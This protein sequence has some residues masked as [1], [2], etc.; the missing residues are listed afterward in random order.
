MVERP[1]PLR[2]VTDAQSPFHGG[3]LAAQERAG[4]RDAADA[5]GRR[6]IRTFMP[7]QHREFFPMLPFLVLGGVDAS[8]RPWPSLRVGEPGFVS[9]PDARSLHV[10]GSVLP[11]DPLAGTWVDGALVGALGI[12][13]ATRRRN[14]VNGVITSG[15]GNAFTLAVNQS[16][17]NCAKYIQARVPTF[18][19]RP[20]GEPVRPPVRATALDAADRAMLA[21]ADTFFIASA[22]TDGGAGAA[23]GADVS[24]RGGVPGFVHV[25]AKGVI[26]SPDFVGNRFFNTIGNLMHDPRAGLLF[27]DFANGDLLYVAATAEIVWDGPALDA[28]PGAQRLI[29]F[30]VSEVVRTPGVLPFRWSEAEMA[31][32]F[33]GQASGRLPDALSPAPWREVTVS[34]V[35]DESATV[36]SFLFEAV[37]GAALPAYLPGQYLPLRLPVPGH[38]KA[39]VRTYTLSEAMLPA[40]EGATAARRY[41]ISVKREGEASA[42]LHDHLQVGMALAAGKPAG[43]FTFDAASR[44]PAVL[45]SAGIGI[46]PMMAM[47][48]HLLALDPGA[49]VWFIHGARDAAHRP[50]ADVLAHLRESH[51]HLSLHLPNSADGVHVDL[52]YLKSVLPFDDYDFYLCGPTAF[53]QDMYDGLRALNVADARIRFEA[54]G[55]A[56]VRR[57]RAAATAAAV[58]AIG[59]GEP[60]PEALPAQPAEATIE[61]IRSGTRVPWSRDDGNLLDFAEKHGVDAQSSCRSGL[62]GTCATRVVDGKLI[63]LMPP[64]ADVPAGH[65]LLCISAP[66]LATGAGQ[67]IRLDL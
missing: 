67:T 33:A 55:P 15:D 51:P 47:L 11:G 32:Q 30:H 29:R 59:G 16:F 34:Q 22:N 20:E 45:I 25:D 57:E 4:V 38:D 48:G 61:F 27:I 5:S 63:Y 6:G 18:V 23:R 65:A 1:Q 24:H 39:L 49:P 26:T 7:E 9:S 36:R 64:E 8:G 10:A 3:E 54:F 21:R 14:R 28:F 17:G 2:A 58:A 52:R 53:M 40:N 44:R 62:C 50:F 19:P 46:T 13:P 35:I 60:V 41:R 42:W 66:D 12:Q 43:A 37:D 31:P 56:S